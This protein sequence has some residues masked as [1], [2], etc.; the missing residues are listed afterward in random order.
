[1]QIS[2]SHSRSQCVSPCCLQRWSPMQIPNFIQ[3]GLSLWV[4]HKKNLTGSDFMG[5]ECL[6]QVTSLIRGTWGSTWTLQHR[7]KKINDHRKK[8]RQNTVTI[9][10]R[11]IWDHRNTA[12]RVWFYPPHHHIQKKSTPQIPMSPSLICNMF[13][14]SQCWVLIVYT[15]VCASIKHTKCQ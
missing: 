12:N 2:K 10:H 6:N 15:L 11:K 7:K 1:M 13:V 8:S 14:T 3:S 5:L 4:K 9:A